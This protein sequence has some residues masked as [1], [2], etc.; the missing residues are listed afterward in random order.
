MKSSF[1]AF[2]VAFGL[3]F[4]PAF[5]PAQTPAPAPIAAEA[6]PSAEE[7]AKKE[8]AMLKELGAQFEGTGKIGSRAEVQI[9]EGY[10]F[11]GPPARR[12][13]SNSGATSLVAMKTACS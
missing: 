13:F 5:V 6:E 7:E 12:S 8:A 3:A 9:P 1:A 10:I 4:A 11:F 2:A